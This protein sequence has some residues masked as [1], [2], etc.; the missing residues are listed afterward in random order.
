[1]C[2]QI[3]VQVGN[4]SA[5]LGDRLWATWFSSATQYARSTMPLAIIRVNVQ[6]HGV[7]PAA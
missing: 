7:E 5:S 4:V 1:V 3:A 6:V 2:P